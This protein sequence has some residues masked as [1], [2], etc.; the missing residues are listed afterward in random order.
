MVNIYNII[1]YLCIFYINLFFW[2]SSLLDIWFSQ[3]LAS[4]F[5]LSSSKV[6]SVLKFN[7]Y[8]IF[9][10][11]IKTFLK[12]LVL[13]LLFKFLYSKYLLCYSNLF[14]NVQTFHMFA[15]SIPILMFLFYLSFFDVQVSLEPKQNFWDCLHICTC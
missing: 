12:I 13:S 15:M 10:F 14:F 7:I 11:N 4:V 5:T 1:W 2:N 9:F 6:Y 8:V 3:A